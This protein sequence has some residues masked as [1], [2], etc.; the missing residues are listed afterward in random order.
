MEMA[1]VAGIAGIGVSWGYHRPEAL[2]AAARI[3]ED[4]QD[5]AGLLEEIW[6]RAG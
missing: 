4:F 2:T 1:R 5:L 6:S 3:V